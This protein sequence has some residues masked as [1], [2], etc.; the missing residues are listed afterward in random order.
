VVERQVQQN[1]CMVVVDDPHPD[2]IP[3]HLLL[4]LHAAQES[5][6]SEGPEDQYCED[7]KV[8]SHCENPDVKVQ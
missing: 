4:V 1:A 5:E 2:Y 6:M 7:G 8:G 3:I